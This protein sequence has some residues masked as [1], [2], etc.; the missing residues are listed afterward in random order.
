[1]KMYHT[2]PSKEQF[3]KIH[4][5][6]D[7]LKKLFYQE[8]YQKDIDILISPTMPFTAPLPDTTNLLVYQLTYCCYQNILELP[9]GVIPTRLVKEE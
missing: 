5:E 7:Q 2:K 1:M 6:L 4:K 9:S 8:W 3:F